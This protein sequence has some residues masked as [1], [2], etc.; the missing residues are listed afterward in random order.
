MRKIIFLALL[1]LILLLPYAAF[2]EEKEDSDWDGFKFKLKDLN[3]DEQTQKDVFAE[4]DLFLVDFWASWCKPCNMYLPHLAKM[5]EEYGD[6]GFKVVIFVVDDAGS[7][8]NAKAT[9][10]AK[11]YPF[12]ILFDPGADVQRDLGVKRIPTTVL[13]DPTGKELW[14]HVGFSSG[15][16]DEVRKKIEENLPKE[17]SEES[18]DEDSD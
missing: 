7:I 11:D 16:E 2:S 13:F 1:A 8:A 10:K 18:E 12:T 4:G 9:L 14:R 15:D 3:G 5:V 6:R 17:S